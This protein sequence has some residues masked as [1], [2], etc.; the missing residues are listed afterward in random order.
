MIY[1][2][3]AEII[4][5]AK[6]MDPLVISVAVAENREILEAVKQALEMGIAEFVLVGDAGKIEG[7][8]GEYSLESR[9][10]VLVDEPDPIKAAHK[11]VEQVIMGKADCLMKGLINSSDFMRAIF[12]KKDDLGI[13]KLL[14]HLAVFEI[15]NHTKLI[16]TSDGGLNIAPGLMEKK[17]IIENAINYLTKIGY[18]NPKVAV[19]AANEKVDPKQPV[20]IEAAALRVMGER[21]AF[22][23]AKVDGPLSLDLALNKKAVIQKKV[24]SEVAGDA[25]LLITPN[26]EAGNILGKSLSYCAMATMA[27]L[28]LGA[29]I[30]I[31]LASRANTLQG[32]IASMALASLY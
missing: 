12:E 25:D 13:S 18:K 21:G 14:S 31:I 5:R 1:R 10:M 3:F 27:G 8:L 2:G 22:K 26:I 28:V 20:T 6:K 15:P 32:E 19:L 9:Q 23:D 16:F 4:D 30:P 29:K 24:V 7:L 11:A 17:Q